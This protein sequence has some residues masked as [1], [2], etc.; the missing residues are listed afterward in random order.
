MLRE[1]VLDIVSI[2]PLCC[3]LVMAMSLFCFHVMAYPSGMLSGVI[4]TKLGFQM[5]TST[6]CI[7]LTTLRSFNSWHCHHLFTTVARL[8]L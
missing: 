1:V 3:L 7:E 2:V 5:P 6:Q 8:G 4:N